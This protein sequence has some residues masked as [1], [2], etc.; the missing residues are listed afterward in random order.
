MNKNMEKVTSDEEHQLIDENPRQQGQS[1][2]VLIN[3]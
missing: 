3:M 1:Q 2:L